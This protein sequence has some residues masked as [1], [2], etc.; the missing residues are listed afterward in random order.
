MNRFLT[1][2]LFPGIITV[3]AVAGAVV[4]GRSAESAERET[5][6]TIAPLVEVIEVQAAPAHPRLRGT[7]TVEPAREATLSPELAGRIVYVSPS[8]VVGGRVA[9]GET[10][11]RI[12]KRDYEIAAHMLR[13]LGVGS[14]RLY[15]NNLNKVRQLEQHGVVVAERVPHV[16]PPNEH[17]LF[18]LRTKAERSGH[19][20]DLEALG[21]RKKRSGGGL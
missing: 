6:V 21:V 17:N 5:P 10:L 16:L 20:L 2:F 14:I 19:Q 13:L 18:Y 9:E 8:L 1:R 11:L 3:A 7:G 4:M 12:D 15:T